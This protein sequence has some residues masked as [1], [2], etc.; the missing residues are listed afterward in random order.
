MSEFMEKHSVSKLIGSPPG[1][2]GYEEGGQL[3]ERVK[4]APYSIILLDEIEKAHP[5]IYNIL[6]QVFEDGQ[7]TD[8]LGNTVDFKNTI[9]IMTSNLGARFLEKRSQ[10]GFSAPGSGMPAKVEDQVMGEVK[11]AFNP[12]FLNRLDEV[13]LFTSLSD[14]DLLKIMH[15][16]ADQINV[17][18]VAKQIKI[19]LNDDAAKYIL[20]KT[21]TDRSYGARPLRRALQK[22]IEDPLSEALIQGSLPRPSELEVY[23]GD[24]GIYCRPLAPVEQPVGVSGDPAAPEETPVPVTP[25]F[26]FE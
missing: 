5:D 14:E 3:T 23:L 7:L 1:Y 4:R 12:E 16:L 19:R 24:G 20:E 17:N 8:G 6:L 18:L 26:M 11:K 13:I 2:V 15:L 25:L 9:I 22:Y 21:C 10:I